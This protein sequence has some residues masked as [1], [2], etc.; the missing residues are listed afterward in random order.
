MDTSVPVPKALILVKFQRPP[1]D[2]SSFLSEYKA[3]VVWPSLEVFVLLQDHI[4]AT[5]LWYFR[6]VTA[7]TVLVLINIGFLSGT[8][9][10]SLLS[11]S[12]VSRSGREFTET[13]LYSCTLAVV[14][15]GQ[16]PTH[17]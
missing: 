10:T 17:Y 3:E 12:T 9:V 14:A 15:V 11:L 8:E 4:L 5:T 1:R 6:D 13:L 16:S 2:S 7:S